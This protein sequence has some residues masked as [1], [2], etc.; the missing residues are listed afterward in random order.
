MMRWI[1]L[2]AALLLGACYPPTTSHPIGA[3]GKPDT[4][5]TGLWKGTSEDGK[6]GYFHFLPQ[7]D[8]TISVII[9]DGGP[10]AEDWNYVTVTSATAG[11]NRFLNARM[12][13]SNGKAEDGAPAGTVP[14]LYRIDAKGVLTLAMMDE[15]KVKAAITAHKIKG[16][17]EPGSMGDATITADTATL[18]AFLKTPAGLALF[19]TPFFTLKKAE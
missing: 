12:L 6:P 18:N 11:A 14:V 8:G 2:A 4:A 1:V 9:T 15:T 17:I 19:D 16:R 3:G 7:A 10:K 5:L 13:L